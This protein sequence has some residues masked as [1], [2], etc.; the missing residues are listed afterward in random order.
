MLLK[1]KKEL[2]L[3]NPSITGFNIGMNKGKDAGQ[4][5]F[6]C[7]V[8]LIPR[9]KG[10]VD[11]PTGGVRNVIPG[12]GN[13]IF[14]PPFA[15]FV[16]LIILL[17]KFELKTDPMNNVFGILAGLYFKLTEYPPEMNGNGSN[18]MQR[19]VTELRILLSND[20]T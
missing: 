3:I 6:H 15:T 11:N 14:V 18:T 4:T 9:R 19:S 16:L 13:V 12:K 20:K 17:G 5:V 10:D 8:H 2:L 1:A 7:H